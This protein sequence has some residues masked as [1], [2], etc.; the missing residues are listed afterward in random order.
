M[1]RGLKELRLFNKCLPRYFTR[2]KQNA[3]SL[4]IDHFPIRASYLEIINKYIIK[5]ITPNSVT[6]ILLKYITSAEEKLYTYIIRGSVSEIE[7]K[8][9]ASILCL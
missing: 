6:I 8:T 4:S 3:R 5:D 9:I 2:F 1:I 7:G